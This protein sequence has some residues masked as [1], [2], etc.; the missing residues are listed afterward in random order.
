MK[1]F[2]DALEQLT[3]GESVFCSVSTP[4]LCQTDLILLTGPQSERRERYAHLPGMFDDGYRISYGARHKYYADR[5]DVLGFNGIRSFSDI[6][7]CRDHE[8]SYFSQSCEFADFPITRGQIISLAL[9]WNETLG[10]VYRCASKLSA[11]GAKVDTIPDVLQDCRLR[12]EQTIFINETRQMIQP[13]S[14]DVPSI[15]MISAVEAWDILLAALAYGKTPAAV[16]E[17]AWWLRHLSVVFPNVEKVQEEF[18]KLFDIAPVAGKAPMFYSCV[19][20]LCHGDNELGAALKASAESD[21]P[22]VIVMRIAQSLNRLGRKSTES[23]PEVKPFPSTVPAELTAK[24]VHWK[25]LDRN[26]G[27]GF[28]RTTFSKPASADEFIR[29]ARELG[30]D[31]GAL[32]NEMSV[33]NALGLELPT[34]EDIQAALLMLGQ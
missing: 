12:A 19:L 4:R 31:P 6:R 1:S 10:S 17:D 25:V 5:L 14:K 27:K 28:S 34:V 30:A 20:Q 11:Y 15:K 32:R 2:S 33:Y 7:R 16:I 29:R 22:V 13:R 23:E 18:E 24:P 8:V 3:G 21:I 26:C 9:Y